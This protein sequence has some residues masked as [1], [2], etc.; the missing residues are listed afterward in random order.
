LAGFSIP[1]FQFL[2]LNGT[3]NAAGKIF[4]YQSGTTTTVTIYQDN[5]LT[6]P[7]PNPLTLD[8][9]G[10][11]KFYVATTTLLRIDSY[12]VN[13][14][15]IQSIDP[16]FPV[17]STTSTTVT[18]INGGQIAGIRNRV[19]NGGMQIALRSAKAA[20]NAYQIGLV[21]HMLVAINGGTAIT[22]NIGQAT[23]QATTTGLATQLVSVTYTNGAFSILSRIEANDC[24]DLNNKTVTAQ[25]KILHDFGLSRTIQCGLFKANALNNFSAVTQLGLVT[26]GVV[27][28]GAITTL[29]ATFTLG[30]TDA[31]NGLALSFTDSVATSVSNKNVYFGDFGLEPGPVATPYESHGAALE[32]TRCRRYYRQS[33]SAGVT[34]GTV[35]ATGAQSYVAGAPRT[36]NNYD[37]PM[38]GSPA[39]VLY[40]TVTGAS[41]FG[42]NNTTGADVAMIVSNQNNYGMAV[43]NNGT[44][45]AGHDIVYQYTADAE[46]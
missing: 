12:D 10:E 37:T 43:N 40:S 23:N 35:T 26:A 9:N 30:A 4:V 16:V 32:T 45:T 18:S 27:P 41:G 21:D 20:T 28:T 39:I 5:A 11:A 8:A 38:L 3:P 13:N 22:G 6:T 34:P 42:R 7:L 29:T 2:L 36:Q 15:F 14:G 25:I 19:V 31:S 33:Y 24:N 1:I 17:G 44:N 46:L